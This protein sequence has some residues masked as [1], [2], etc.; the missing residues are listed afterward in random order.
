[1]HVLC[2]ECEGVPQQAR[3]AARD[4]IRKGLVTTRQRLARQDRRG[5]H[6]VTDRKAA[7]E[8]IDAAQRALAKTDVRATARERDALVAWLAGDL[9]AICGATARRVA[10]I[11]K[12]VV[13]AIRGAQSAA[14]EARRAWRKAA[15]AEISRREE[16]GEG[17]RKKEARV[18]KGIGFD[19]WLQSDR[20]RRVYENRTREGALG[21]AT[22]EHR[23]GWTLAA[24]L[25]WYKRRERAA[26]EG[27]RT[28][29]APPA[30]RT[31]NRGGLVMMRAM[32]GA[33]GLAKA[34]G[35]TRMPHA[36][37]VRDAREQEEQAVFWIEHGRGG[38]AE[39]KRWMDE[40]EAVVVY[41]DT[42][43][44]LRTLEAQ[45]KGEDA[46]WKEHNGKTIDA[47][48]AMRVS[49]GRTVRLSALLQ[50]NGWGRVAGTG[51]DVDHMWERGNVE[52]IEH[53]CTRDVAAMTTV[54]V[55]NA[56][57]LGDGA[58]TRM[59]R[60]HEALADTIEAEA[61]DA[62]EDER[63]D[64]TGAQRAERST[65]TRRESARDEPARPAAAGERARH[66]KRRA[67]AETSTSPQGGG[68]SATPEGGTAGK[69]RRTASE[70]VRPTRVAGEKRQGFYD[71][72][73]RHKARRR[74]GPAPYME[75]ARDRGGRKRK[76]IEV[77]PATVER[78]VNGRYEWRDAGLRARRE[79]Q[80]SEGTETS[81]TRQRLRDPG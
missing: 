11:E 20:Q 68:P 29:R 55:S 28:A 46:R 57:R 3:K 65:R 78:T 10:A 15:S 16:R 72:T 26:A 31:R 45:Y 77:G 66:G 69:A 52:G 21:T 47:A 14:A 4:A 13:S 19:A 42:H 71:Q 34:V 6:H 30:Q 58:T 79:N 43:D 40:A 49:L 37:T 73:R 44:T 81:Q 38:V 50:R 18:L 64:S 17:P 41:N 33:D 48:H 36:D 9:P 62:S 39:L 53:A 60:V 8:M 61:P 32:A 1:M 75:S 5:R 76:A 54:L 74:I 67:D 23:R 80:T 7:T 35:A 24:M 2:G 56:I 25:T 27:H 22:I 70:G 12:D 63:G 51:C 59:A